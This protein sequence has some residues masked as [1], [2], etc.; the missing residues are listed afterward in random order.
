MS[1][2]PYAKGIKRFTNYFDTNSKF[3]L[4]R[5]YPRRSLEGTWGRT[6][7]VLVVRLSYKYYIRLSIMV[8]ASGTPQTAAQGHWR[9]V[10]L[11]E[12]CLLGDPPTPTSCAAW[13]SPVAPIVGKPA[14]GKSGWRNKQ[15][16][17]QCFSERHVRPV[18]LTV[19]SICEQ[20]VKQGCHYCFCP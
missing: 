2:A 1:Y 17:Q 14:F 6:L 11:A 19:I 18:T 12:H 4:F 10:G 16:Y 5:I 7:L 13:R 9:C 20:R 3:P 8:S 15:A